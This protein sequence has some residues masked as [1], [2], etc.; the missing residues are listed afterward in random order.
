MIT[1]GRARNNDICLP[2]GSVSK[3]HAYFGKKPG[4]ELWKLTDQN[5]TNGTLLDEKRIP[6]G[7]SAELHDGARIAFGPD[8][9]ARYYTPQGLFG[10]LALCRAGL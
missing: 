7:G 10:Y 4:T 2:L 6:T 9:V 3:V 1:V 5:A 8:A